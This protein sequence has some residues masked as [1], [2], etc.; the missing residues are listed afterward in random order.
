MT[1]PVMACSFTSRKYKACHAAGSSF[2]KASSPFC[3][4]CSSS[5]FFL[6]Q[7]GDFPFQPKLLGLTQKGLL[8]LL[9]RGENRCLG[10]LPG[11]LQRL[12]GLLLGLLPGGFQNFPAFLV[13]LLPDL[14]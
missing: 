3:L 8:R 6:V 12:P 9:L 1:E 7:Q 4:S 2:P 14:F 5:S 13:R 11:L 10:F